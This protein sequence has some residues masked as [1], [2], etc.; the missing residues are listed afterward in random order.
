M[1]RNGFSGRSVPDRG[2]EFLLVA[3]CALALGAAPATLAAQNGP[4]FGVAVRGGTTGVGP[5]VSLRLTDRIALRSALGWLPYEYESSYDDTRY[6]VT[7]PGRY[8]SVTADLSIVGPLRLTGGLLHRSGP[9]T[10]DADLEGG[11]QVGDGTYSSTGR[12]EG[13]V[14]SAETAPYLGLGLGRA[15]GPGFGLYVDLAVAFIG[16]PDLVLEASGPITENPGFESDLERER[17]RA[18]DDLDTYYRYWP[19]VSLGVRLPVG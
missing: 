6:T 14:R 7:P 15:A 9:I 19:I 2:N 17:M 4:D 8:L 10:F 3:L 11:S 18:E 13:E 16:D 12:L 5:E 1:R